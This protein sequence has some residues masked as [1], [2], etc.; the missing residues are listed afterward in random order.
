MKWLLFVAALFAAP[1]WALPQVLA[2]EQSW[3]ARGSGELTWFGLR[4]YRATL[5]TTNASSDPPRAPLALSLEY[6]REIKG[7]R[8][9]RTSIE[10]MRRLGAPDEALARWGERLVTL[11]PDVT[12]GDKLTGVY[13]PSGATRFYF[14]DRALGEITDPE[15]APYFF[16]IWLDERTRAPEVREALM[17]GKAL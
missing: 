13:L 7:A 1:T 2:Q 14:H 8:I 9:A 5:W 16:G 17:R 6:R 4:V 15:F 11:F 10:E 12:A 3:Q